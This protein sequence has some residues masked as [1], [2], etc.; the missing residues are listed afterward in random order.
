MRATRRGGFTLIELLVVIGIIGLLISLLAPQLVKIR[1]LAAGVTDTIDAREIQK[2]VMQH[3]FDNNDSPPV[4]FDRAPRTPGDLQ[5]V[6]L[7]NG[8]TLEGA[9]MTHHR[10]F[11]AGLDLQL[12]EEVRYASGYDEDDA[13]WHRGDYE[14]TLALYADPSFFRPDSQDGPSQWR[15]VN[16]ALVRATSDKGMI[17]QRMVWS[18]QDGA[19]PRSANPLAANITG[20][21]A[22]FDGSAS[23]ERQRLMPV[24][25]PNG[26]RVFNPS[27]SMNDP[28][29]PVT[30]TVRGVDGRDRVP[31]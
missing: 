4:I 1:Q 23:Q 29:I 31:S 28:G 7:P 10:S 25:C 27:D 9:W 26:W 14:L 3:A 11:F 18:V 22:W 13:E 17:R 15:P 16:T 30:E 19:D 5:Q 8:K 21:V 12:P 24:G 20:A 6:T 2:T